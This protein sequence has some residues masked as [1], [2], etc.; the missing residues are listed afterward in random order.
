MNSIQELALLCIEGADITIN[1]HK[2]S[3][4]TVV[5]YIGDDFDSVKEDELQ[6]MVENDTV[7][8]IHVTHELDEGCQIL[9]GYNA[10]KLIKQ[11]LQIIKDG[12]RV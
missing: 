6:L 3:G 11:A 2:A 9:Y 4:E 8:D 5:E 10:D 12:S 1:G 7:I